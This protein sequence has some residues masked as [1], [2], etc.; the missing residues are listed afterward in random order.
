[1]GFWVQDGSVG[2]MAADRR[3]QGVK[4]PCDINPKRHRDSS[5][6]EGLFGIDEFSV[7]DGGVDYWLESRQAAGYFCD[8]PN[9]RAVGWVLHFSPIFGCLN[10]TFWKK[11]GKQWLHN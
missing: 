10:S 1:M 2:S 4:H 6:Q 7:F 3:E 5:T 8:W 9:V 11:T